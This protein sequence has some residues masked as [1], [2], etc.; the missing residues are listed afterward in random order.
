[1]FL[2][3]VR[4]S[5]YNKIPYQRQ[6]WTELRHQGGAMMYLKRWK[7]Y[8]KAIAML[9]SQK[10]TWEYAEIWT[11][12]YSGP[13]KFAVVEIDVPRIGD[14][15]VL[16]RHLH[17]QMDYDRMYTWLTNAQVKI[18]ACGVCGTV[19]QWLAERDTSRQKRNNRNI[20]CLIRT[21]ITT[22]ASF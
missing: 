12:R 16:V 20:D 1:M 4:K 18:S 22:R 19:C 11:D 9:C 17:H 21:C 6:S 13:E 5:Y 2:F 7:R 15:D 10:H 14:D 3:V 8:S